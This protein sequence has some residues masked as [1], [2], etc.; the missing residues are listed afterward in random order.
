MSE[1]NGYAGPDEIFKPLNRRYEEWQGAL[2]KFRLRTL[3]AA[4]YEEWDS[5]KV[6]AQGK[7]SRSAMNTQN[8]RLIVLCCVN[9]ENELI[10]TRNDVH[11]FQELDAGNVLELAQACAK[12]NRLGSFGEAA[13]KN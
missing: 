11:R 3:S 4:E 13:E 6:N 5:E 12:H 7:L 9:S 2:G 8:A 1:T 10:F